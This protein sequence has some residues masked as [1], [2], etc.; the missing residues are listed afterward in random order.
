MPLCCPQ[1]RNWT[2]FHSFRFGR[3]AI[4]QWIGL[5]IFCIINGRGHF[6]CV[7]PDR[8][9]GL[10]KNCCLFV[11]NISYK[12]CRW[13]LDGFCSQATNNCIES[14][15]KFNEMRVKPQ[16]IKL[17]PTRFSF[18]SSE[19]SI[20]FTLLWEWIENI[21]NIY[22]MIR[23]CVLKNLDSQTGESRCV[24]WRCDRMCLPINYIQYILHDIE[25]AGMWR[26]SPLK[27]FRKFNMLV[28][29][30]NM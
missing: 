13:C 12:L 20:L 29:S 3:A 26:H 15:W 16:I 11:W 22:V 5:P 18:D 21:K 14:K 2:P 30:S 7:S 8:I 19:I 4:Q 10:K 17:Y 23:C 27:G 6:N 9:Y 25:H 28:R 1:P 24:K